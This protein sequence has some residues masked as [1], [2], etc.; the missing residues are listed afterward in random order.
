MGTEATGVLA[1]WLPQAPG[2]ASTAGQGKGG[3]GG[4][5]LTR[6]WQ[7]GEEQSYTSQAPGIRAGWGWGDHMLMQTQG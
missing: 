4:R 1:I 6:P 7:V 5:G 3:G 2:T